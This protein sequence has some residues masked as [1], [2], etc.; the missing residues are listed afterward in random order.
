VTAVAI[1][2]SY[3]LLLAKGYADGGVE[4]PSRISP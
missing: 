4:V 2:V 1:A 3:H